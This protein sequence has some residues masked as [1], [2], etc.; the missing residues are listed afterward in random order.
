MPSK[1]KRESRSQIEPK[2]IPVCAGMVFF[3]EKNL[4]FKL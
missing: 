3:R 4:D 1:T 2:T